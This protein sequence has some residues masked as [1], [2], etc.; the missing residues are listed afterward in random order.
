[1]I[2]T[3]PAVT[4]VKPRTRRSDDVAS[5]ARRPDGGRTSADDEYGSR[6]T[7][8]GTRSHASEQSAS[9]SPR[10]TRSND[11]QIA[12]A[13]LH[14]I[15][16]LGQGI[17][18]WYFGPCS[19]TSPS[20]SGCGSVRFPSGPAQPLLVEHGG[21]AQDRCPDGCRKTSRRRRDDSRLIDSYHRDDGPGIP[22]KARGQLDCSSGV[23]RAVHS[24]NDS[25]DLTYPPP[26]DKYRHA[27]ATDDIA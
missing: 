22:A 15:E 5:R 12:L 7:V 10:A 20:E 25:T 3:P 1:M 2:P 11:Q 26:H 17:T 4:A 23:G 13:S 24:N 14:D 6:R 21:V 18:G 27:R 9:E 8:Q 16:Q 19:P